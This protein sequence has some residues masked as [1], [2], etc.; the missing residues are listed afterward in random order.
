MDLQISK[1]NVRF[2]RL[3]CKQLLDSEQI[4]Q[5]KEYIKKF[6]FSY[7]NK[8][9]YNDGISFILYTR[10]DALKL[11]PND[12][13]IS[14]MKP[15]EITK[16]FEKQ[17]ISIKDYLKES[18][19]LNIEYNPT[20]DFN[21]PLIFTKTINIRGHDFVD[22]FLNMAKPINY[23][24][25]TGKTFEKTQEIINNTNL[26]Y[27]HLENSLCS[28]NK[29][30]YEYVLNFIACTIG[31]RKLRKCLYLQSKE[32]SGKG[33]ILNDVLKNILG[34]RMYKTNSVESILKYTK[35]FEGCCLIN[36]DELPHSADYKGVQDN[37]KGLITEPT[38]TCRDMYS[39]GYDQVNTF[40]VILT[41][42]NDAVS[43]SQSNNSRYVCLDISEENIGNNDYF[44]KLSK[45][46]KSE[47][48]LENFYNEMMERYKTV[49]QNWNEDTMPETETRKLKIIEALPRLYKYIKEEF[50]LTN[51]GIDIR[52]DEFLHEYTLITKDKTSPQK[53]GRMLKEINV[54]VVKLSNNAGYKYKISKEDLLQVFTDKK[55]IDETIDLINDN[56]L[57]NNNK[58]LDGDDENLK[59][60]EALK[61]Q[62]EEAQNKIKELETKKKKKKIKKIV[63]VIEE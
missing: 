53:I 38:F 17:D 1:V 45:A 28:K 2:D 22:N 30:C 13:K 39:S 46:I 44:K 36:F 7:Q 56:N 26:I 15:N 58:N 29:D 20:I 24:I 19:F 40:N 3:Y 59:L 10:E 33:I 37:L 8:I 34:S 61:L 6:F 5:A 4:D 48:V 57:I 27:S 50:I 32:R 63:E 41:T 35:P 51:S 18:E 16:K 54:K 49:C 62:L 12:L 14:L 42:N 23:N 11:I 43:L 47:H 52:T 21:K 60:I 25:I 31:G 55:W 9:F